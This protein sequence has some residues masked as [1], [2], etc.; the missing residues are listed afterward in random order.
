MKA[1][2]LEC[3]IKGIDITLVCRRKDSLCTWPAQW[4]VS[5]G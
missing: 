4:A 5:L 2:V 1:G 3:M